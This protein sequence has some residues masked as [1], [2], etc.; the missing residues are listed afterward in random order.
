MLNDLFSKYVHEV[1]KAGH[2][3]KTIQEKYPLSV[4]CR[5]HCC[6]CC[7]AVF[8]VFPIEAAYINYH[9]N[10]L[11]RKIRRDILRRAEKAETEVLKTKDKLKVFDDKPQM[12]VYGL[13]KQRVRCP[14][15]TDK[16]E[17]VLYEK[18]PIICRIYGVPFS[19]KDGD[20]E[21]AYVCGVSGFQTKVTYPTVKLYKIY[22]E[23][24]KLSGELFK[25]TGSARPEKADLMLPLSRI[26]RMPFEAIIKG[27]F[28]E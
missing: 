8:G 2:L 21:K 11:D 26:L 4:C 16:E 18:R 27:D 23:L 28:E 7:H 13:G 20:K 19:L 22:D 9:F 14:L 3:F 10:R 6:D 24:C 17:C 12:K 1:Q 5:I 25:S 15:L